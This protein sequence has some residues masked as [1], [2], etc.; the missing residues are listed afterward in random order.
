MEGGTLTVSSRQQ[1]QPSG[2]A[3]AGDLV[4]MVSSTTPTKGEEG[5]SS[6]TGLQLSL[7][8]HTTNVNRQ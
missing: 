2:T 7:S 6:D 5:A 1:Q 3:A 8:R 4:N